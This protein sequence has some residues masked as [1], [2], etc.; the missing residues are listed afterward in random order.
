MFVEV[1]HVTKRAHDRGW[2][3]RG[4][5][6]GFVRGLFFQRRSCSCSTATNADVTRMYFSRRRKFR[7]M[8]RKDG[9]AGLPLWGVAIEG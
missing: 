1:S 6:E 7:D 2:G 3:G 5:R 9:W 4:V 8:Y